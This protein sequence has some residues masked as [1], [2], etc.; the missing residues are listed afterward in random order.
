MGLL[1]SLEKK[2]SG[3]LALVMVGVGKTTG[4]MVSQL[5][6][7][8]AEWGPKDHATI[9]VSLQRWS[10]QSPKG[11]SDEYKTSLLFRAELGAAPR[12][13]AP[14]PVGFSVLHLVFNMLLCFQGAKSQFTLRLTH[15]IT[16]NIMNH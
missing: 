4:E 8:G 9:K 6:S 11:L 2:M 3:S 7:L 1:V 16:Y 5:E 15:A 10:K 14:S 13:L 12:P